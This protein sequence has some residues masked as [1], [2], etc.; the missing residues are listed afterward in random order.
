MP[1]TVSHLS[2]F[3]LVGLVES[4]GLS[5]KAWEKYSFFATGSGLI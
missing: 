2:S 5:Q 4:G 1:A 3:D